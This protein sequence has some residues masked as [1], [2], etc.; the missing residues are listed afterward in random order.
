MYSVNRSGESCSI[1]CAKYRVC[2]IH[3]PTRRLSPPTSPARRG[4]EVVP[5][6]FAAIAPHGGIAVAE[7][8]PPDEREVAA[9]TRAGMEELGR[10]FAATRPEVVVVATPHNVHLSNALGVIVASRVAG[11]LDGVTPAVGLDLPSELELA[12]SVLESFGA[13][14]LPAAGVSFGSNEPGTAVAPMDWGVLIPL[15]FMGGR[16]NPPL[17]VVVVTPSRQLSAEDHVTA[18]AA[19]AA[20][21]SASPRR[22]A[23]IA[24]ADHG[25]AH[26]ESGPYGYHP[27]AARYDALVCDLVQTNRLG[28]LVEIGRDLVED[29]K[30][31]SW[32][33]MLMLHGATPGWLGTLVSYE[34]PTYF[35]MLTAAFLPN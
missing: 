6:V 10:L 11:K 28:G 27:S 32:W 33:Q 14:G 29:A 20:A 15:W 8:C 22:V 7:A 19:I 30:A 2:L 16:D 12:R 26:L 1:C 5:L 21:A 25:H 3:A 34:A 17:P 24:S 18:G 13:A 9:V 35:G 31:D 4:G 23:F